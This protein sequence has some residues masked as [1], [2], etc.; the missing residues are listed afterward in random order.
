[1]KKHSLIL[2]SLMAA[3]GAIVP[4]YASTSYACYAS[5]SATAPCVG[6]AG[7]NAST[8]FPVLGFSSSEVRS[9][10]FLEINGYAIEK[11]VDQNS[12]TLFADMLM[13]TK[14]PAVTMVCLETNGG[15]WFP[16]LQLQ[17]QNVAVSAEQQFDASKGSTAS[18]ESLFLMPDTFSVTVNTPASSGSPASSAGYTYDVLTQTLTPNN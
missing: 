16:Y 1:M 12:V 8:Y 15:K 17:M 2:L 13:A 18:S 10:S 7:C 5:L 4:S 6:Q 3:T 9:G 11:P 14:I